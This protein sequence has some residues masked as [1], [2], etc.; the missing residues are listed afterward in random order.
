MYIIRLQIF[1]FF[2]LFSF[3]A[4][5]QP[6][7]YV[8]KRN[9][10]GN[11]KKTF[12]KGMAYNMQERY[13][14]ALVEFAKAIKAEPKFI[15]AYIVTANI[16]YDLKNY[17][18]AVENYNRA[19]ALDIDY[20]PNIIY[21]LALTQMKQKNFA[22]AK[23]NFET[24]IVHPKAK[25]GRTK[26]ANKHILN[27]DFMAY[28]YANPVPFDPKPMSE[29]INKSTSSEYLPAFTVDEETL[30]YTVRENGNEDF[31]QSKK[32]KGEWQKGQPI[33][34]LNTRFN[35][36]A[37]SVS[38]DGKFMVFT[39]CD[40]P[41]GIGSCDLYFT[42][43]KGGDRW[44]EPKPLPTPLNHMGWESQPSISS[45]NNSIFFASARSG[46][47]GDYDIWISTK[48]SK[49][50]YGSPVNLG[51][52]INTKGREQSPFIHADG[53]TL[54]FMS[55]GH[56]GL[57]LSDLFVSRKG[58]DGKW[59]KPKNLG[60]P[61]NTASHEGALVVSIDG[62]T[63]Y[64]A[65]DRNMDVS[66]EATF[67]DELAGSQTDIYSF[68]LPPA[69]R[70]KPVTYVKA[71][72]FD[73]LTRKELLSKVE[74]VELSTGEVHASSLTDVDGEFLVC[75]P[76]GKNY[77]LNVSKEKYIFHS[78]NFALRDFNPNSAYILEIGLQKIPD[79]L[80]AVNPSVPSEP[81]KE[82]KPIILKNVFFDTGSA[83]LR[84]ESF[85]ELD[86]LRVLLEENPKLEIQ[87]NGHTDNV[88]S[89]DANLLLSANRAKAVNKYLVDLGIKASRLKHKGF[90]ETV[91][92]DSNETSEGRQN[93]RRTEFLILN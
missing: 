91:P 70:P 40:R 27:C 35:E 93:N 10:E 46:G 71:K 30:I 59:G 48:N 41:D 47:K 20:R 33:L 88:G 53:E 5:A 60:Y 1:A 84:S 82:I 43:F 76:L 45:D 34:K 65:S 67:G 69:V 2:L 23:K 18:A 63:A 42:Q 16:Q 85:I 62:K 4:I 28:A 37:Q 78:E 17:A 73:A 36:G 12:D 66:S 29:N 55:D 57:G 25:E 68:E 86:R 92:I 74:F 58:P 13:D 77:S 15:D 7:D 32:F 8:S 61:I 90:G 19:I 64:F 3:A 81:V 6:G 89:D 44:T 21:N 22:E 83:N 79:N 24:Y 51:D 39:A 38:A 31:Y 80:I 75:L 52:S 72:V 11:L 26:R 87:I 54:F 14:K 9:I 49:G 50:Q 56:P